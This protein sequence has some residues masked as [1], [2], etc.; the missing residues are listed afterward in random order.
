MRARSSFFH[1]AQL[2]L[3]WLVACG[4]LCVTACG[5]AEHVEVP[6]VADSI[7]DASVS[8]GVNVCPSIQSSLVLPQQIAPSENALVAV[9]AVDPDGAESQLVFRWTASSGTFSE[10]NKSVTNYACSQLGTAQLTVTVTDGPGCTA[11][12]T[13]T[14]DCVGK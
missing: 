11:T 14:V 5:S 2:K 4:G 7:A 8:S 3:S 13:L 1:G 10:S 12:L 9:R 6:R